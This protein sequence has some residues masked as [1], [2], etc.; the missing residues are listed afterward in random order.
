[1]Y[2][3]IV[4]ANKCHITDLLRG[5]DIKIT[6]PFFFLMLKSETKLTGKKMGIRVYI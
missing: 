5:N 3:N 6:D 2:F 1:M 4:N